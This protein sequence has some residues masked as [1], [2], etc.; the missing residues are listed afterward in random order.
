MRFPEVALR[1]PG[2]VEDFLSDPDAAYRSGAG[3]LLNPK[4]L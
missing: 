2:W 1:L 4:L 3:L